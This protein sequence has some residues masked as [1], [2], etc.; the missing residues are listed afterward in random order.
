MAVHGIHSDVCF[1]KN[2]EFF[3]IASY[4]VDWSEL[5]PSDINQANVN[6]KWYVVED[7]LFDPFAVPVNIGYI[8]KQP[9]YKYSAADKIHSDKILK[10]L[11]LYEEYPHAEYIVKLGLYNL[12]MSKQILRKEKQDKRCANGS[13][14]IGKN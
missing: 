8:L 5:S 2:M 7:K 13:D 9:E 11:R 1:A 3:Y 12:A 10:Y 14:N 6:T 4:T